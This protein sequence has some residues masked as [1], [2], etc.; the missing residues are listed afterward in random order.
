[1]YLKKVEICGFKSFADRTIF[2][3]EPEIFGII[4]GL[5]GCGKSKISDF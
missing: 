4:C 3:F 5:M 1:M 2:N